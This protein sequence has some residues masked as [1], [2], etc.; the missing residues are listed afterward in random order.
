MSSQM[1]D[2]QK[3]AIVKKIVTWVLII[4]FFGFFIDWAVLGI[5]ILNGNYDVIAEAYIGAVCF[6]IML[7]CLLIKKFS[8]KCPHCGKI[9]NSGGRFCPHCGKTI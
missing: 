5:K 9:S 1:T 3:E 4:A 7:V 2:I 8:S 6:V